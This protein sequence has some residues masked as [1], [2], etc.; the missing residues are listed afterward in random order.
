MKARSN[1]W[2][3]CFRPCG[4]FIIVLEIVENGR[5]QTAAGMAV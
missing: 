1:T 3:S 4:V 2:L 5:N